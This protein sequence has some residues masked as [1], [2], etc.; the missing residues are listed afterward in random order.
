MSYFTLYGLSPYAV[1]FVS[2]L[3]GYL[4]WNWVIKSPYLHKKAFYKKIQFKII[5][6]ILKTI[7]LYVKYINKTKGKIC[8]LLHSLIMILLQKELKDL[9]FQEKSELANKIKNHI[10]E[11]EL[12]TLNTNEELVRKIVIQ[13]E[14]V[15]QL[16]SKY[17]ILKD[18]INKFIREYDNKYYVLAKEYNNDIKQIHSLQDF[19]KVKRYID[20]KEKE[21]NNHYKIFI[22]EYLDEKKNEEYGKIKI[23]LYVKELVKTIPLLLLVG[24][25]FYNYF[26]FK[27]LG[28][29]ISNFFT[30]TDYLESSLDVVI[31]ILWVTG[32]YAI[33]T[34]LGYFSRI[35]KIIRKDQFKI[36]YENLDKRSDKILYLIFTLLVLTQVLIYYKY[37][38]INYSMVQP[39]ILFIS[40]VLLGNLFPFRRIENA[41][42]IYLIT[43]I[44]IFCL[45][46]FTFHVIE[47][48]EN[49]ANN[50]NSTSYKFSIK[51]DPDL[52]SYQYIK[53]T[54]NYSF[55]YSNENNETLIIPNSDIEKIKVAR[56]D[57]SIFQ[58]IIH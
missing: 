41:H 18:K 23:E 40:Y 47:G 9:T 17:F 8:V 50:K 11:L 6:L 29:Q 42:K 3:I 14:E 26:L 49:I 46:S 36:N 5:L 38:I 39:I 25:F 45:I 1:F 27:S 48:I 13:D 21:I 19:L 4:F 20:K 24:G 37:Q 58:K 33:I 53:S 32:F 51:N 44:G 28:I 43:M 12:S 35:D 34:L 55:F 7:P 30:I 31:P 56:N 22:E 52:T 16:I 57:K 54:S 2:L 10:L 15:K